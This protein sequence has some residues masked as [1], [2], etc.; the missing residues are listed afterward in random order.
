MR[1]R[2]IDLI[3][4]LLEIH[5]LVE[6]DGQLR[7]GGIEGGRGARFGREHPGCPGGR[8]DEDVQDV[9]PGAES[10]LTAVRLIRIVQSG[11]AGVL[12]LGWCLDAPEA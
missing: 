1:G 4:E 2:L 5:R 8:L 11:C 7:G 9:G 6:P 10:I 3:R 12:A